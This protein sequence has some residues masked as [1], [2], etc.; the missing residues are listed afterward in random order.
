MIPIRAVLKINDSDYDILRFNQKFKRDVDNKGYPKG[1]YYGGDI[2]VDIESTDDTFF[3]QSLI[4]KDM[5]MVEGAIEILTEDDACYKR[6][7][8][9]EAYIYS[10]RE[11]MKSKSNMQMI[12]T[13]GISFMYLNFNNT[14]QI[15]RLW[16]RAKHG[17]QI[18]ES[19]ER[20]FA[21]APQKSNARIVDAYW[22]DDKQRKHFDLFVNYPVMLY[23]EF[24]DYTANES[25]N[26]KFENDEKTYSFEHTGEVNQDG[27][28]KIEDFQF[29]QNKKS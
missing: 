22:I 8:F 11:D 19:E 23:V 3:F 16:P 2:M 18:D 28:M 29:K 9:K 26:L 27:I 10:Y 17:W 4:N 15:D 1:V 13:L 6:I 25:I 12:T 24:E 14:L 20:V 21:K 5:P 7:D